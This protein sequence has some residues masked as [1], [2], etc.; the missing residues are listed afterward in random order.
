MTTAARNEGFR[1]AL[2]M[3]LAIFYSEDELKPITDP[4]DC[5]LIAQEHVLGSW[6]WLRRVREEGDALGKEVDSAADAALARI[7]ELEQS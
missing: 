7:A 3:A 4:A 2:C 1:E 5:G 6:K